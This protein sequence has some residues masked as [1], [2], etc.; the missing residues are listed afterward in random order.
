[1]SYRLPIRAISEDNKRKRLVAGQTRDL[2]VIENP[3]SQD[4]VGDYIK[5]NALRLHISMSR[6]SSAIQ[7]LRHF[8]LT[9]PIRQ[10]STMTH[11]NI[12]YQ[13]AL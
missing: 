3:N 5:D 12:F 4:L 2:N 13:P 7:A 1:M 10:G 9:T 8:P 6:H 11:E